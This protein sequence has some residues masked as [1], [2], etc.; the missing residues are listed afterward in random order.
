MASKRKTTASKHESE[1]DGLYAMPLDEF[2]A[3]RDEL[4]RRLRG[5]GDREA[6][7]EVKALRKPSLAAWA[8]NQVRHR[9]PSRVKELLAA[10]TKLQTAQAQLV[11]GG[12]PDQLR[13]AAAAERQMVDDVV[14]LAEKALAEA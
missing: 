2:T 6:A 11:S 13:E 1:I 7:G 10:G 12:K 5:D 14:A 8:L 4:A 3:A 9:E